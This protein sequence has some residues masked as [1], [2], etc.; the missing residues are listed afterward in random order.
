MYNIAADNKHWRITEWVLGTVRDK[1]IQNEAE[2]VTTP[3]NLDDVAVFVKGAGNYDAICSCCHLSPGLR[4]SELS[5]GLYPQ[6]PD[7]TQYPLK[8]PA[9]SF[10]V[11]KHGIKMTG[12]PAWGASHTDEEIWELVAFIRQLQKLDH[13]SYEELVSKYGGSHQHTNGHSESET[14]EHKPHNDDHDHN[15]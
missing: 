4:T 5:A 10:W 1:S 3:L 6:P 11:I 12:M 9:R 13:K 14:D 2:K 7:L 8:D 15:H